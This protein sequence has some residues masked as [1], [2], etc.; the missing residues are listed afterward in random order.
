[1]KFRNIKKGDLL[2]FTSWSDGKQDIKKAVVVSELEYNSDKLPYFIIVFTDQE[3]EM[4][5]DSILWKHS[6]HSGIKKIDDEKLRDKV[7]LEYGASVI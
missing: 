6:M 7:L 4:I 5:V 3:G 1:M 2:Q